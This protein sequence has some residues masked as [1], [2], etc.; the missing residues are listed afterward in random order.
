MNNKIPTFIIAGERRS[1]TSTLAKWIEVHPQIYLYPKVDTAFFLDDILRGRKVWLN[2]KADLAEWKGQHSKDE[3]EALFTPLPNQIA[4]GEKSADYFF[5]TPSMERIHEFYPDLKVI[6]TFRHPVERAWS[7]YWN[8]VGKGRENLSFEEAI[9]N[10]DQ[11]IASSDY[12]KVHLSYTAR[13]KYIKSLEYLL[14][15]KPKQDIHIVILEHLIKDPINELKKV[16]QFL[17][18]DP[19]KGLGQAGKQF[20]HNWTTIPH[21]FWIETKF[22]SQIEGRI[23]AVVKKIVRLLY[24][25]P[26]ER[27]KNSF[28][29]ERVT[30]IPQRELK[31]EAKTRAMLLEKFEPFTLALEKLLN[32]DL[33]VWKK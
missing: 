11:R 5:W 24:K 32:I 21:K 31:M 19:E 17:G 20:N 2:G 28:K 18:V 27:R 10:E 8:E 1:G 6:L 26:Y 4:I 22:K 15:L 30:R 9:S 13:G 29:W 33:S 16:Y 14:T 3:Y 12:A 23:N 25:D 7:H